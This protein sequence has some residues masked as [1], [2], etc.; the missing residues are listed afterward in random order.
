MR[1][2]V[3]SLVDMGEMPSEDEAS[4]EYV[5]QFEARLA[6]ISPPVSDEEA[7]ALLTLFGSPDSLYG[8]AWGILHL[9]ESAPGWPIRSCLA[10]LSN[11]WVSRLHRRCENAGLLK[12]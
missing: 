9:V 7:I 4:D 3:Q 11:E 1:P 5:A 8:L 10:D 12:Q 2:E 6:A